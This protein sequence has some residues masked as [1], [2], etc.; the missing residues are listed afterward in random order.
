MPD[1][2]KDYVTPQLREVSVR[3]DRAFCL[4]DVTGAGG[5]TSPWGEDI[6]NL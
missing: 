3:Y 5:S 2:K 1:L 4:S 6:E